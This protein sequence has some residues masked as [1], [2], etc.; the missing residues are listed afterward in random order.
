ME[1]IGIYSQTFSKVAFDLNLE[2]EAIRAIISQ[3]LEFL[4]NIGISGVRMDAPA[5]FGKE[6]GDIP[7]HTDSS[8]RFSKIYQFTH[9]E[10]QLRSDSAIRL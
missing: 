6:P 1:N 9:K 8:Y 5:Y 2:N 10:S 7:R 3:H 4:E